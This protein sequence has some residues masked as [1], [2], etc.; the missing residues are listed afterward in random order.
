[1]LFVDLD[2]Y[3]AVNDSLG[4]LAGDEVLR[5]VARRLVGAVRPVDTMARYGGDEFVAVG[6]SPADGVDAAVAATARRIEA[7]VARPVTVGLDVAAVTAS[8]GAAT[9]F[10]AAADPLELLRAADQAA[11]RVKA[12][13]RRGRRALD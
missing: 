7:A 13:A 2:G 4:H 12:A 9:T 1:M 3:K 8:V 11:Y 6:V 10:D 5:T